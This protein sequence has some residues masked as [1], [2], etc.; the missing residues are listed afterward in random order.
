M[1]VVRF[2]PWADTCHGHRVDNALTIP[3][4][5]IIANARRE[6]PTIDFG[7]C[8]RRIRGQLHRT[9]NR[10]LFCGVP[11]QFLPVMEIGGSGRVVGDK[12]PKV[13]LAEKAAV[14]KVSWP[15]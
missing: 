14:R 4:Q 11:T 1:S 10:R 5:H 8:V 9:Y 12:V 13:S 7:S 2:R 6:E 3:I 15:I